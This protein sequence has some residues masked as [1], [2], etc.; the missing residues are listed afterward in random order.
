MAVSDDGAV[1]EFNDVEDLLVGMVEGDAGA[2]LE[3]AA[4]VGGDD[5]LRAR[6]LRVAH[7]LG[8]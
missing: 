3:K 2:E 5:G 6:G 1:E 4:G 8:Q 7:F